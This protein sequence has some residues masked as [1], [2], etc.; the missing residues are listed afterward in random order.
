MKTAVLSVTNFIHHTL[1]TSA[2][3]EPLTPL[4]PMTLQLFSVHCI[5]IKKEK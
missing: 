1:P 4:H 3:I 5:A 2:G